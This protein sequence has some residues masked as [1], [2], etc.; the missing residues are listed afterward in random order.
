MRKTS[1][2]TLASFFC[3]ASSAQAQRQQRQQVTLPEGNG[4]EVVQVICS[5]CHELS[6]VTNSG[7]NTRDGWKQ[8][9]SSMVAFRAERADTVAAYL[10][11]HYS[12]TPRPA[13][14]LIS[15]S[16]TVTIREWLVPTLG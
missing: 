15:G 5:Q 9:V 13:A 7:G 2:L 8:L 12:V 3:A 10:A 4:K 14:V 1:I 11:E 6:M 16:T